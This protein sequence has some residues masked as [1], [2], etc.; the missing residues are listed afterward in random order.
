VKARFALRPI[1]AAALLGLAA[2]LALAAVLVNA[3]SAQADLTT[4]GYS[5]SRLGATDAPVGL[6]A[7]GA[8]RL[9]RVWRTRLAGAVN[10]QPLVVDHV[11]V[12]GRR[13]DLVL[14]ATEHAGVFALDARSGRILWRR[15]VG[16]KRITPDCESSPDGRFGVSATMVVDRR[17]GELFAADA[18]GRV[19]AFQL[20]SGR[21]VHGWPVA[22]H[23][24]DDGDFIWGALAIS[25][26]RLYVPIASL[27]DGGQYHGGIASLALAHPH[28]I[29]V[30]HSV[31]TKGDYAGGIW[32][33][34]GESIDPS[35]GQ[36]YAATGNSLGPGGEAVPDS[37]RVIRLTAGLRVL[38]VNYPLEPPFG[39]GDRDFG[40]AP[41]LLHAR[42][43]PAQAVAIN[44]VGNLYLYDSG[45]ISAGPVQTLAVAHPIGNGIPLYGM[46]AYDPARRTLV[47]IS[48]SA[49]PNSRLRAGVQAFHLGSDCRLSILWQQ[50]EFDWPYAGSAPTIADGVIYVGSGRNGRLLVYRLRDGR[51]L[52]AGSVSRRAVMAAPAV[53][54]GKVF[55]GDWAGYLTA[56][57]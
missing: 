49:P 37:E 22:V 42:G 50:P 18:R 23:P 51:R 46:P 48:P 2:L 57:R 6:G 31:S 8:S 52:W 44:K 25:R 34:G 17:S 56:L 38:Q 9:H 5:N 40:T 3:A 24:P 13:R 29:H 33:W 32:G 54:D 41:V 30:W 16:L 55:V 15:R 20:A 35:T 11:R 47:L 7:A 36:L 45:R 43:C 39:I 26:G 4:Y 27:C 10:G 28:R 14:V 19:W 12:R 1:L 21:D 53:A